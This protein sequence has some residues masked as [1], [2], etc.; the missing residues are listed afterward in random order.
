MFAVCMPGARADQKR[1]SDNLE[2]ELQVAVGHHTG[3]KPGSSTG[4]A[5]AFDC[6]SLVSGPCHRRLN[7]LWV[8]GCHGEKVKIR[9]TVSQQMNRG[10][11]HK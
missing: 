3:P 4:A 1:A 10:C 9:L 11:R 8:F 2:L 5:N 7:D 6:W